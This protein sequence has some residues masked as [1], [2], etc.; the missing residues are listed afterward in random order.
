M[1]FVINNWHLFVGLAVVSGLLVWPTLQQMMY[2]ISSVGVS[3]ALQLINHQA[4]VLVDVREPVETQTGRIPN[5]VLLPLSGMQQRLTELEKFKQRPV[6]L[7]CRSGQRSNRAAVLLRKH[8]FVSVYNLAGGVRAW[9][10]ENLP[11]EK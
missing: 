9:Q 6:V 2:G 10:A 8:G 5:S 4:G 1:Q 7:C 3:Q 11:I